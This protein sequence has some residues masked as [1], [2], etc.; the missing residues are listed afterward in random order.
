[1]AAPEFV[2]GYSRLLEH[3]A[4]SP[5]VDFAVHRHRAAAVATTWNGMAAVLPKKGEV[6]PL[7]RP[8]RLLSGNQRQFRHG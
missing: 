2:L 1:M 8:A 3:T 4:Q 5:W 7:E 6:H